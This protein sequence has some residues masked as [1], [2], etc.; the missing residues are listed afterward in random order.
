[1]EPCSRRTRRSDGSAPT[2]TGHRACVAGHEVLDLSAHEML[3]QRRA[4][5]AD[6]LY[7]RKLLRFFSA[8]LLVTDDLGLRPLIGQEPIDLYEVIRRDERTSTI[9]ISTAHWPSGRRSSRMNF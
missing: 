7:D 2:I 8:E 4:A 9:I 3:I 6:A 1:M 5:R